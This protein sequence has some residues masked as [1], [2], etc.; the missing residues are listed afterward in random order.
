MATKSPPDI[1]HA[2]DEHAFS[3][4]IHLN[5]LY[6]YCIFHRGFSTVHYINGFVVQNII[7]VGGCT[8][9]LYG[10][11]CFYFEFVFARPLMNM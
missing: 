8:C 7:Y 2:N 10:K 1:N 11:I 4:V 6:F 5:M 9:A 3:Y